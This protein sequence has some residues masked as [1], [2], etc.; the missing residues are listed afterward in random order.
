MVRSSTVYSSLH[1]SWIMWQ[2]LRAVA[3]LHDNGIR[4]RDIKPSNIL[5]DDD[6]TIR[7]CDFGLARRWLENDEPDGG[8]D[9]SEYVCSR[10]YRAPECL[11]NHVPSKSGHK[12]D[13]WAVGSIMAEM[14]SRSPLFRGHSS[15]DQ[16]SRILKMTGQH[17]PEGWGMNVYNGDPVATPLDGYTEQLSALLRTFGAP[18]PAVAL[19][20]SL[21][22]IHPKDRLDAAAAMKSEYF[23]RLEQDYAAWMRPRNDPPL[24]F[25]KTAAINRVITKKSHSMDA[26]RELMFAELS[27]WA[28]GGAFCLADDAASGSDQ[29]SPVSPPRHANGPPSEPSTPPFGPAPGPP[30]TI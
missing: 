8:C 5:I 24:P 14:F 13:L 6:C 11:M 12:I 21:L 26:L 18:E 17:I 7:L 15:A 25:D 30:R 4:H 27:E 20:Q 19:V 16:M 1:V 29:V 22:H 9:W 2:L 23:T 10:W 28:P 3:Y